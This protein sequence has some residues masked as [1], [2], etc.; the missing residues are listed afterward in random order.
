[1]ETREEG[2]CP[3]G[4]RCASQG[5]RCCIFMSKL[6]REHPLN[7]PAGLIASVE[8]RWFWVESLGITWSALTIHLKSPLFWL[9]FLFFF[10]PQLC[11]IAFCAC[12]YL[13]EDKKNVAVNTRCETNV[14]LDSSTQLKFYPLNYKTE[15]LEV[16]LKTADGNVTQ[17]GSGCF[18]YVSLFCCHCTAANIHVGHFIG[19]QLLYFKLKFCGMCYTF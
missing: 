9:R 15:T 14:G 16:K 19:P 1:M 18:L 5:G 4:I 3:T 10:L 12:G 6:W 17:M 2:G 13:S 7:I 11:K 8:H